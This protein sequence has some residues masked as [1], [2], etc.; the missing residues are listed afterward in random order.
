MKIFD[1]TSIANNFLNHDCIK[2]LSLIHEFKGKQNLYINAYKDELETL[3]DVAFIQSVGA[4]NRIEGIFTS[5]KRLEELVKENVAPNNRDDKEISGY[6]EVLK[7]IHENYDYIDLTPNYIKELHKRLYS[8]SDS[9]IGG[10]YKC[11]DNLI[12]EKDQFGKEK[13]RFRPMP[14]YLTA[15]AMINVCEAFNKSWNENKIDKLLLIPMFILDFLCIHPFD[16]GNGRMSR[17]LTLL[18]LYKAG[19]IVGKYI[20]IEMLIEKTKEE[21]YLALKQS[22]ENWYD[23]NSNYSFFVEYFLSI[24]IKSYNEFENRVEYLA[25]KKINKSEKIKKY[26]DEHIGSFNKK[27][28]INFFPNISKITIERTLNELLK[29][30]YIRKIG[31]GPTTKYVKE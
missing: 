11:S 17:L 26:I 10:K 2:T 16:D 29:S 9:S 4:S 8:F 15:D 23:N 20:S 21:Y 30:N 7:L 22:S 12:V 28:I 1:Y 24:L 27:D 3:L 5:D 25:D 19:Y 13:I 31:S 14:S 6:R 18:L